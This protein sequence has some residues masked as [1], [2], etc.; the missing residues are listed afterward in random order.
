MISYLHWKIIELNF[1][2]ITI[3][4]PWGVWYEVWIS[5]LTY[6]SLSLEQT[7]EMPVYHHITEGHQALFGFWDISEKDIFT[8]LIKISGIGGKVAMQM[9][10]LW[11]NRLISSVQSGDN[12]AIE[13]IKGIWKKM[14]EKVILELKDKDFITTSSSGEKVTHNSWFGDV[15]ATLTNMWYNRSDVEKIL[16]DLPEGLDD[17]GEII[18]YVIK[19]I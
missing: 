14:A 3:M 19:N 8:Q 13:S 18:P 5:E 15:V 10:P 2:S 17:I 1:N 11:A 4:T 6:T 9:L 16:A 12:K 7:I